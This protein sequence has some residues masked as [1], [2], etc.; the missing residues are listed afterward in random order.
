MAGLEDIR[1][2]VINEGPYEPTWFY[3]SKPYQYRVSTPEM[4]KAKRPLVRW[5][6]LTIAYEHWAVELR[7]G[8]LERA[9]RVKERDEESQ[10]ENR[11]AGVCPKEFYPH[12][13]AEG[14]AIRNEAGRSLGSYEDDRAYKNWFLNKVHFRLKRMPEYEEEMVSERREE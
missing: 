5:V 7:D 11:L 2:G 6:P 1:V 8:K 3:D 4:I 10:L 12:K 13:D 9:N 14:Q